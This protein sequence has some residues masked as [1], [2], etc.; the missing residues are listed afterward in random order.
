MAEG[1]PRTVLKSV[2]GWELGPTLGKGGFGHVR[3]ATHPSGRQAAVKILPA[4]RH[5]LPMSKDAM[6]DAVE[7][8]KEV[9]MLKLFGGLGIKGVIGLDMVNEDGKWKYLFLP[10]MP[11]TGSEIR[12]PVPDSTFIP[13]FRGLLCALHALHSIGIAHEDLKPANCLIDHQGRLVLADLGFASFSPNERRMCGGGGTLHY[14]SP[15]KVRNERY[16]GPKSD[17]YACGILAAKWLKNYNPF[18]WYDGETDEDIEE[19]IMKGNARH[20]LNSTPGS[21]GEM[22][23]MMIKLNP[24]ERSSIPEILKHPFLNPETST[25]ATRPL[26]LPMII[27]PC[28]KPIPNPDPEIINEV[29]FLASCAGEW[30]PVQSEA[31]IRERLGRG[32]E[33]RQWET[34]VYHGLAAWKAK[35][36]DH[37]GTVGPQG[38]MSKPI[39]KP[40]LRV[41]GEINSNTSQSS[42]KTSMQQP[43]KLNSM[44]KVVTQ[45]ISTKLPNAVK[46]NKP[47]NQVDVIID[48]KKQK[49]KDKLAAVKIAEAAGLVINVEDDDTEQEEQDRLNRGQH[50]VLKPA[51]AKQNRTK[52]V[53]KSLAVDENKYLPE[54]VPRDRAGFRRSPRL[55]G[56]AP[57]SQ[58]LLFEPKRRSP[59]AT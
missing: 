48:V 44:F 30:Y 46:P 7:A 49:G 31:K 6:L 22:I 41:L 20:M 27:T 26:E 33:W 55:Q 11:K 43:M 15:E 18:V 35:D 50:S 10:M 56:K 32:P 5:D 29:L 21:A 34:R 9:I 59:L 51:R 45:E 16:H 1:T 14:S 42:P 54:P 17:I 52:S 25:S 24:K 57:E 47:N 36:P 40:L 8:H 12:A 53:V 2:A 37:S 4:L 13:L 39:M 58:G 23:R 28:Y 3:K 38:L 19:R